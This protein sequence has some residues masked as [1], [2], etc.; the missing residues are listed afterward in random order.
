MFLLGKYTTTLWAQMLVCPNYVLVPMILVTMMIGNY[1]ARYF[2]I[3]VWMGIGAGAI[4]FF[5]KRIDFPLSAFTLSFVLAKLLENR[6]RRSLMLSEGSL[7]IFF[8][9]PYCLAIWMLIALM[10]WMSIQQSKRNRERAK[11]QATQ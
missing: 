11:Q 4:I 2:A 1:T 6:F 5:V 7:T 8:T 10:V 9:R 3:D